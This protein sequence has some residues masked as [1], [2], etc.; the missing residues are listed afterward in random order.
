[1]QDSHDRAADEA[2][3]R[4]ERSLGWRAGRGHPRPGLVASG[5]CHAAVLV[6]LYTMAG[7]SGDQTGDVKSAV[8]AVFTPAPSRA[9]RTSTPLLF[10]VTGP[11]APP[12]QPGHTFPPAAV[13]L[14]AIK[15]SF[16]DD[17]S[18]QLPAVLRDQHGMLALL[19]PDDSSVTQYLFTPPAWE[20]REVITDISSKLCIRMDPPGKW[21]LWRAIAARHGIALERYR[22]YAVFD[23][24]YRHCLLDAIRDRAVAG[25]LPPEGRVVA[26]RLAFTAARRCGIEV[27][28]VSLANQSASKPL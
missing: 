28:E 15:V 11:A 19:D 2:V 26:V 6:A 21:G 22:A 14:S 12:P 16:A 5:L 8:V 3:W 23:M 4:L 1:M 9:V 10:P 27:L 18:S 24:A 13:D 7:A 17:V 20:M 25:G